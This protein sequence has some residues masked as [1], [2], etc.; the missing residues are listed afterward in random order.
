MDD[1]AASPRVALVAEGPSDHAV[2]RSFLAAYFRDPDI[3][4]RPLQPPPNTPGGWTEVLRYLAS[5][6]LPAAFADN[7][8]VVVQ[9]DTDVC[10]EVGYG[11]PRRDE[12]GQVLA[13]DALAER[14]QVRL[15]AQWPPDLGAHAERILFAI[16]VDSIECWLLPLVHSDR[17]RERT[18]NCLTALNHELSARH[19]YSIDPANKQVAY[20]ERLL[21]QFKCHKHT[22]LAGIADKHPSLKRFIA[23]LDEYFPGHAMLAR[24]GP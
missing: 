16:C 4:V 15:T 18:A 1:T 2:L 10:E 11:V 19:G 8:Y 5:P 22:T 3:L 12:H 13:P 23:Q 9:I 17:R 20:Y 6:E 24:R 21:R 7:D 14:V